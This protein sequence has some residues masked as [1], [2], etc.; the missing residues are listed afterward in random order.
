M[1]E[2]GLLVF[3]SRNYWRSAGV[4]V[5]AVTGVATGFTTLLLL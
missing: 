2:A 4:A 3:K 1:Q 5:L